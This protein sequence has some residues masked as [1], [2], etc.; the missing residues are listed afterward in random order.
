MG[1]ERR[2]RP[3]EWLGNDVT[4]TED[5]TEHNQRAFYGHWAERIASEP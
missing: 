5:V 2:S 4:I 3:D 1:L